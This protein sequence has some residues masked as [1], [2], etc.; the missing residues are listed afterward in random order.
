MGSA[1]RA[2]DGDL[3]HEEGAGAMQGGH[4][5]AGRAGL[6]LRG[7]AEELRAGHRRVGLVLEAVHRVA[8]VG[9]ADDAEEDGDGARAGVGDVRDGL[10]DRDGVAAEVDEHRG[11]YSGG[12]PLWVRYVFTMTRALIAVAALTVAVGC[13]GLVTT[14]GGDLGQ[15]AGDTESSCG[16]SEGQRTLASRQDKPYAIAAS[17][18][19]VYWLDFTRDGESPLTHATTLMNVPSCGGTPITLAAGKGSDGDLGNGAPQAIALDAT[20]VYWL[21]AFGDLPLGF[22]NVMKLPLEGG[23]PKTLVSGQLVPYAIAVDATS[24]YWTDRGGPPRS[25]TVMKLPLGGGTPITLASGRTAPTGIALDES[26]VYWLDDSGDTVMKMPLDGG[27]PTTLASAES[28]TALAVDATSVYWVRP[29]NLTSD[30]CDDERGSVMKLPVGGGTPRKLA[31]GVEPNVLTVV[32]AAWDEVRSSSL[33]V[34]SA[35]HGVRAASHVDGPSWHGVRSGW[36]A[37]PT[38]PSGQGD[39]WEAG[40][41]RSASRRESPRPHSPPPRRWLGPGRAARQPPT[42]ETPDEAR[43]R[44]RRGPPPRRARARY[45]AQHPPA[46]H[47][48]AI[49]M[50]YGIVIERADGNLSA[51]APDIPGCVAT[52]ATLAEVRARMADAIAMHLDGLREDGLPIPEPRAGCD[53][54][55]VAA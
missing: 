21:D 34:R 45:L 27:T 36:H 11:D 55:V 35:S 13:G 6:D 31:S 10:V 54:V 14:D 44:H 7:D 16:L 37:V 3:A 26:S 23:E 33:A 30:P 53:Y 15:D 28:A 17:S 42:A 41:P 18:A 40:T 50:R 2:D 32:P 51:Y 25:G 47:P 20:S 19:G 52:G 1:G 39:R 22:G 8:L 24:V 12:P 5:H 4:A 38:Q 48:G 46:S 29:T 49:A 43:S 9:V